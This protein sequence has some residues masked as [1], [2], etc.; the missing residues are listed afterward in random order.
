MARPVV[1]GLSV[2]IFFIDCIDIVFIQSLQLEIRFATIK[3]SM[4]RRR[5][6]SL[7]KED[8]AWVRCFVTLFL[9]R[10]TYTLG[11]GAWPDYVGDI[12]KVIKSLTGQA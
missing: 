9:W 11:S 6:L 8:Y 1:D 5:N 12:R 10:R 3:F 7:K 2:A 4:D